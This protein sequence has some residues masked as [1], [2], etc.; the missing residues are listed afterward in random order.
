MKYAKQQYFSTN[1]EHNKNNPGQTWTLISECEVGDRTIKST[2]HI[3]K[4][5]NEHFSNTGP[6]LA[7]KFHKLTS[8]LKVIWNQ[9]LINLY[10]APSQQT[11]YVYC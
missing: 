5:F 6:A 8:A 1:L 11:A 2:T 4:T 7:K 10:E 3:A 9:Q